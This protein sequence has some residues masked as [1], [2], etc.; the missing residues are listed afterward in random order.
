MD[1][2]IKQP[3]NLSW[4]NP[5]GILGIEFLEYA[6]PRLKSQ[7]KNPLLDDLFKSFAFQKV[8]L[9]ICEDIHLYR[10]GDIQFIVNHSPIAFAAKFKKHHGPCLC[11]MALRVADVQEALR[12]TLSKGARSVMEKTDYDFPAIYGIGD[13]I[14][15]FLQDTTPLKP[16]EGQFEI[17]DVSPKNGFGLQKVDHLTNN[18]PQGE[19][20]RWQHF[21][22]SVFHFKE[23]RYFDIRGQK[24]GLISKVMTS[25]NGNV[26]IPI[27]EPTEEKSQIQEYLN[28]YRGSGIQHIALLTDDII[29]TVT[30]L[31]EA[32]VEFL[33]V[34]DAYYD[35]LSERVPQLTEDIH[36]LKDLKI[37]ADGDHTGYLLQIFTKNVI[38]PI[39]FEIIQRK[40]HNGFGEGNFQA[41]FDAI[42]R[43]QKQRGFL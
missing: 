33:D 24:T 21:Y 1:Q 6:C 40:N 7:T 10:Q 36:Q 17:I 30:A 28:T 22:E 5:V 31:R 38:G 34:P 42:E 14:I 2:I 43:D 15:Y 11:S 29:Y 12:T 23:T 25:S 19:M 16:Y 32:G 9:H 20:K 8:G 18:V 27:N 41:L 13:S 37:L 39:F 35:M 26:V 4:D 3:L